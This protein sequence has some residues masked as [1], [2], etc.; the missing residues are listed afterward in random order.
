M[1]DSEF[2]ELETGLNL[3]SLA[4]LL[5]QILLYIT[6]HTCWIFSLVLSSRSIGGQ[7]VHVI[8]SLVVGASSLHSNFRYF[9]QDSLLPDS[10]LDETPVRYSRHVPLEF[11]HLLQ[12]F[13]AHQ[14]HAEFPLAHKYRARIRWHETDFYWREYLGM[15]SLNIHFFSFVLHRCMMFGI[16]K[17]WRPSYK[18]VVE[19]WFCFLSLTYNVPDVAQRQ[20]SHQMQPTI[21]QN[22]QNYSDLFW[23]NFCFQMVEL[24]CK[25][26]LL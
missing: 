8:F 2:I 4:I 18:K 5:L 14:L 15:P 16:L 9:V 11:R 20:I 21:K 17:F 1:F 3:D 22:S 23:Q 19:N 24:K 7:F 26:L 13:N 10:E 25:F 6:L 12:T